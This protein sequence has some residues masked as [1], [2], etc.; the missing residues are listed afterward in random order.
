MKRLEVF[1]VSCRNFYFYP[2]LA[3]SGG[4]FGHNDVSGL[5]HPDDLPAPTAGSRAAP[6]TA[7]PLSLPICRGVL[8]CLSALFESRGGHGGAETALPSLSKLSIGTRAPSVTDAWHQHH[9]QLT[10]WMANYNVSYRTLLP[11]FL[12]GYKIFSWVSSATGVVMYHLVPFD[13]FMLYYTVNKGAFTNEFHSLFKFD[14][15]I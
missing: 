3:S 5:L 14:I 12:R 4:S 15:C 1:I 8:G 6:H 10:M 9:H 11:V 13:V 7:P 2:I